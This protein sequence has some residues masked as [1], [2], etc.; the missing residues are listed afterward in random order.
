VEEGDEKG[1]AAKL[2]GPQESLPVADIS[3]TTSTP[4]NLQFA[5]L[6]HGEKLEG[7]THEAKKELDD[8][9]RHMLH[10]RRARFKR[11]MRAF[12]QYVRRREFTLQH[13]IDF[14]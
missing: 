2:E 7:W 12:W 10:S 5:V 13:A 1:S 6:P 9:V 11:S 14:L 4:S 8:L 3:T